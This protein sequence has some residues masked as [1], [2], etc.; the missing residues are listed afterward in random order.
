MNEFFE[1]DDIIERVYDHNGQLQVLKLM[2]NILVQL[3]EKD[4]IKLLG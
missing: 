4:G 1:R 2:K 3:K